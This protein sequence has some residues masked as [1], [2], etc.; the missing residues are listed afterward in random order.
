MATMYAWTN[1]DVERNEYG[2]TTNVIH[3]GDV[4][5]QADLKVSDEDWE[6]LIASGAVR[7]EE[8]PEDVPS[9]MSVAEF[10][11]QKV[12]TGD[13]SEEE[14]DLLAAQQV[15]SGQADT[16]AKRAGANQAEESEGESS[17]SS[18]SGTTP[19]TA[20]ASSSKS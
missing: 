4:V 2:Q 14:L 1:F 16:D 3:V 20:T 6:E 11:R 19:K 13:A 17:S 15:A 9:G 12:A 8:Y 7:E 5:T 10:L 18:S